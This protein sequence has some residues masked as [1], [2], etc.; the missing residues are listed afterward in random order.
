[1][2]TSQTCLHAHT[3]LWILSTWMDRNMVY[4]QQV[5]FYLDSITCRETDYR[6]KHFQSQE[7]QNV[8][9]LSIRRTV[10]ERLR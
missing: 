2:S 5:M 7:T 10:I 3:L 1:M 6:G 4:V 8:P 9:D